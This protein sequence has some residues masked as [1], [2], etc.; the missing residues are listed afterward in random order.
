MHPQPT[1][2]S[3][4]LLSVAEGLDLDAELSRADQDAIRESACRRFGYCVLPSLERR[5]EPR[6]P[7]PE[8]TPTH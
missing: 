6:D 4:D 3:P 8:R 7:D 5:A 2:P 1:T